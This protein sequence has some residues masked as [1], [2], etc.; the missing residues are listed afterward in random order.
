[1]SDASEQKR[2]NERIRVCF[3][4][5]ITHLRAGTWRDL[6][7]AEVRVIGLASDLH[8]TVCTCCTKDAS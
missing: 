7:G 3:D 6:D 4:E 5:Q 2:L 8:G 1:M